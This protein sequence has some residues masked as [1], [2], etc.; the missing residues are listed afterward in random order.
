MYPTRL[1]MRISN[2]WK[3][4]RL[5]RSELGR[6]RALVRWASPEVGEVDADTARWRALRDGKGKVLREG[7]TFAAGKEP[8]AWEVRRSVVGRVNQV[9]VVVRGE[10]F[11]TLGRRRLARVLP[12]VTGF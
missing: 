1:N 5:A 11:R 4:R 8:V 7:V 6:K 3:E 12:G 9:D 10:V 2:S